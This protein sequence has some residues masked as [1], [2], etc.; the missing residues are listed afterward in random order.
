MSSQLKMKL[1]CFRKRNVSVPLQEATTKPNLTKIHRSKEI[2]PSQNLTELMSYA[3]TAL[4]MFSETTHV[5]SKITYHVL[6]C[7]AAVDWATITT[8]IY[9]F[10]VR[11]H[12]S[13]CINRGS[14]VLSK[15]MS[16]QIQ[17]VKEQHQNRHDY[18][19]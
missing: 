15:P 17:I 16:L 9:I 7:F 18:M 1:Y 5:Q 4:K 8:V 14:L 10:Y 19:E 3:V 11:F 12:R 6:L 2:T 13:K